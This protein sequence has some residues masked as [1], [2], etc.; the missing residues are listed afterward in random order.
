MMAGLPNEE[1]F[2]EGGERFE[3]YRTLSADAS[4][5]QSLSRC[6]SDGDLNGYAGAVSSLEYPPLLRSEVA[7]NSCFRVPPPVA[8]PV[9]GGGHVAIPPRKPEKDLSGPF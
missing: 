3:S 9:F 8:L 6:S 5:Y 4:E 1:E 7:L 2:D